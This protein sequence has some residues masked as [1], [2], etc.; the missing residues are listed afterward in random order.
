MEGANS[1]V[2]NIMMV[3]RTSIFIADNEITINL[4][5]STRCYNEQRSSL[6][7][8]CYQNLKLQSKAMNASQVYSIVY[9][10]VSCTNYSVF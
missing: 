9:Q 10:I 7:G 3:E 2:S 1:Y 6:Y 8:H 4:Y 5:Q